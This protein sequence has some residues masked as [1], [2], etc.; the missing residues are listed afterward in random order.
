MTHTKTRIDT[1][2]SK[3]KLECFIIVNKGSNKVSCNWADE[4]PNFF[5]SKLM[6]NIS[7]LFEIKRACHNVQKKKKRESMR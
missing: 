6:D 5:L 3:E 4:S 1:S 2:F 7:I